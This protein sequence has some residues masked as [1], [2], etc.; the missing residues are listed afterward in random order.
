MGA[1]GCPPYKASLKPGTFNF[2]GKAPS[3]V[4]EKIIGQFLVDKGF[5]TSEDLCE[6]TLLVNDLDIGLTYSYNSGGLTLTTGD[7]SITV[8]L[9]LKDTKVL[10]VTDLEICSVTYPTGTNIHT[11]LQAIID[12]SGATV[13]TE[14]GISGDG[15]SLDKIRLGGELNQ[16]TT[17]D[18]VSTYPMIWTDLT[19]FTVATDGPSA[20]SSLVVSGTK[21]NACRLQHTDKS[22][23]T[24]TSLLTVDVDSDFGIQYQD[25]NGE[26]GMFVSPDPSGTETLLKLTTKGIRDGTRTIGQ[27]FKLQ[28]DLTGE[29][30]WSNE[31][32]GISIPGPYDDDSDANSNGVGIGDPYYVSGANPWGAP[33]D[34]VKIRTI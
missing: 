34:F 10:T 4:L 32:G 26:V 30:E 6:Y 15:S 22:D 5:A 33:E 7:T 19:L 3:M 25:S 24:K 31:T 27:V 18:G 1:S 16:N 17:V 11:I 13:E 21:S 2:P 14:N 8:F 29:G 12:C 23:L 20:L 28:D 9:T